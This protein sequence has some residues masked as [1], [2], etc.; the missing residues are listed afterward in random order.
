MDRFLAFFTPQVI[1]ILTKL[2]EPLSFDTLTQDRYDLFFEYL[3]NKR[4]KYDGNTL[5]QLTIKFESPEILS[6]L[7]DNHPRWKVDLKA[8][9]RDGLC[10]VHMTVKQRSQSLFRLVAKYS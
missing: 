4:R 9:N 8:K 1:E 6:Y 3:I 10:A 2:F 5:A 7:L